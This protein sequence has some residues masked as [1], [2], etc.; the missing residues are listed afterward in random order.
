MSSNEPT[1]LYEDE[2]LVFL[3]KPPGWVVNYADTHDEPT[4]QAWFSDYL[5]SA[6]QA[7]NWEA[8]VPSDFDEK[9]GTPEKIW[10]DRLGMIH[11]LDKET[12]G[13]MVWAK[14]PGSL[15]NLLAQFKNRTTTKIYTCLVHGLFTVKKERIFL[16]MGRKS[17]N[18]QLFAVRPDGR[19]AVT[20]YEVQKSYGGFNFDK[21]KEDHYGE[22][23]VKQNVRQKQINN[24]Y[25]GFSLVACEPKTGRTHQIR[26]HMAHLKHPLVGDKTYNSTSKQRLDAIW[27]PRQFLHASSLEIEHPRTGKILKVECPLT[28]DLSEALKF[29][30]YR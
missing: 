16:P 10:Q 25:Q 30:S 7:F 19:E 29:L 3:T 14:N 4:M 6:R 17:T 12:S 22:A 2:D 26:V 8:L 13:V 24:L 1:I 20:L 11:R 27:C 18:R 21:L 28:E 15:V 9:Y 5:L 23:V